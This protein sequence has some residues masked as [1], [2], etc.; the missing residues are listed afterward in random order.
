MTRLYSNITSTKCSPPRHQI[1][2]PISSPGNT[3]IIQ[4]DPPLVWMGRAYSSHK[5]RPI[6]QLHHMWQKETEHTHTAAWVETRAVI[7]CKLTRICSGNQITTN[8]THHWWS[9]AERVTLTTRSKAY[10]CRKLLRKRDHNYSVLA[11]SELCTRLGLHKRW[12]Q[13]VSNRPT[14]KQKCEREM[15][16]PESL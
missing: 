7:T 5:V 4:I 1:I 12:G 15:R 6:L 14:L 13:S 10:S 9:S 16:W 3:I 2:F 11:A 8:S